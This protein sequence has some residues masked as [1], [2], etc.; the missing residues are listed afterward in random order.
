V[1]NSPAQWPLVI[2]GRVCGQV[3]AHLAL[4]AGLG[5]VGAADRHRAN[6]DNKIAPS[7]VHEL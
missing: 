6:L 3:H 5:E 2:V 7:A 1:Q 4:E